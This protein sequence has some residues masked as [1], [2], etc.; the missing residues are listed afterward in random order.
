MMDVQV[1]APLRKAKLRTSLAV[2]WLRRPAR[3]QG[4]QIPFL[5][6]GT[7]IPHATHAE[8]DKN[9]RKSTL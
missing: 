3:I 2:Q 8:P 6:W 5:G 9:K 7:K 1:S 4:A